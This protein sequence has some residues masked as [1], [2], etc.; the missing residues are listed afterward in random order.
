M[1]SRQPLWWPNSWVQCVGVSKGRLW[2]AAQVTQCWAWA[3][4]GLS[5]EALF[6]E[7]IPCTYAELNIRCLCLLK[8]G[9][10]KTYLPACSRASVRY[11]LHTANIWES[12]ELRSS[13]RWR[14]SPYQ[15]PQEEEGSLLCSGL[16]TVCAVEGAALSLQSSLARCILPMW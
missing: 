6:R 5:P 16:D 2:A 11:R 13:H 4:V 7:Y 9:T 15:P 3:E 14:P 1:F 10:T 12:A 8:I